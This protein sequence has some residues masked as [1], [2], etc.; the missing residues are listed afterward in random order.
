MKPQKK[1]IE[2]PIHKE[3]TDG[4]HYVDLPVYEAAPVYV[5]KEPMIGRVLRHYERTPLRWMKPVNGKLVPR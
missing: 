3:L 1:T 2:G 4:D 5:G